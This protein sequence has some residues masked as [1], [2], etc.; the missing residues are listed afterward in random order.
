MKF[1]CRGKG[2]GGNGF[3]HNLVHEQAGMT[4]EISKYVDDLLIKHWL[5]LVEGWAHANMPGARYCVWAN[6]I[7]ESSVK[8]LLWAVV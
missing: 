1:I 6:H 2:E 5:R 4:L 8:S 3:P 7:I